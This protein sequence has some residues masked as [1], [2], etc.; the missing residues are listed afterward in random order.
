[1]GQ[2]SK[3]L[4]AMAIFVA[5]SS[6]SDDQLPVGYYDYQVIKLL[7]RDS[8]T[9]WQPRDFDISICLPNVHYLFTKLD[10]S[11]EVSSLVFDCSISTFSDTLLIGKAV[12]SSIA[13]LYSDS[14]LFADGTF[15]NITDIGFDQFILQNEQFAE[16]AVFQS[17]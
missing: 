10:D 9:V 1:M 14:L 7:S 13:D 6:C 15:W 11:L 5:A 16:K 17:R 2:F 3:F 4:V 12:P 8:S